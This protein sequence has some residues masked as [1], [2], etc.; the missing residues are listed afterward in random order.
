MDE[1]EAMTESNDEKRELSQWSRSLAEALQ[2]LDLEVEDQ[3]ILDL[4]EKTSGAV[5]P[6]AGPISAFLVGFAAGQG[7]TSGKA[8]VE[9]SVN[10]A[11]DVAERLLEN[12][13][14]GRDGWAG[15][16]Q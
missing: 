16:A 13:H 14:W 9:A 11:I 12:E 6:S 10:S 8:S 15:T 5:S 1:G 3:T 7:V 2:I 4:A